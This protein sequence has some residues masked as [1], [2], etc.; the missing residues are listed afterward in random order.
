ME[1]DGMISIKTIRKWIITQRDAITISYK[2]NE[3]Y[4]NWDKGYSDCLSAL[5]EY[6]EDVTLNSES[7][8][9]VEEKDVKIN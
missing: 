6:F 2:S 4:N 1:E 7:E 5:N 8:T 9:K 3:K